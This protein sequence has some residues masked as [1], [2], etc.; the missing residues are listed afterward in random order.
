MTKKILTRSLVFSLLA[1]TF[2]CSS[3]DNNQNEDGFRII[4]PSV[5]TPLIQPSGFYIANEDWFGTDKGSVNFLDYGLNRKYRIYREA[6]N[7]STLGATTTMG[8]AFGENYYI[9]S[10]QENKLV[11]TDKDFK[12]VKTIKEIPGVEANSFVGISDHKAYIATTNGIVILNTNDKVISGNV[13]GVTSMTGNMVYVDGKVYAVVQGKGL[14]IINTDTDTVIDTKAGGY[15]QVT[16]DKNG[17]VWAGKGSEIERINPKDTQDTKA[18]NI[19]AAP[20]QGKWGAWNP[21]S[22]SPSMKEDAIYWIANDGAWNGGNKIAKFDTKTGELNSEFYEL[23]Q[24]D[25]GN[26]L[27]FYAAGLRVDPIKDDLVLLIKRPGWGSNGSYNWTRIVSNTGA[28]KGQAF[29]EGGNQESSSYNDVNGYFWFPSVPFFQDNNA[30]EILVNQIVLKPNKEFRVALKDIVVDQD[31][32]YNLI[33][34]SVKN[35][36]NEFGYATIEGDELVIKTNEKTGKT[37]MNMKVS[38]NGKKLQKD[39]EIWVRN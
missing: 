23:G 33:E 5:P 11:I 35:L 24:D 3:D 32:P 38:S 15:T 31:S 21:G 8:V 27:E 13:A 22:M 14:T 12:E 17:I 30:P 29:M 26:N 1:L 36:E 18:Y 7:G 25:M 28:L 39:V 6:N 10:K 9:I 2:A 20:I 19:A 37:S 16:L 34:K 4:P